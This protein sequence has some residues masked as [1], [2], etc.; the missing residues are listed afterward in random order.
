MTKDRHQY[1]ILAA[2][3]VAAEAEAAP[4][5]QVLL[6]AVNMMAMEHSEK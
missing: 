1:R 6:Q 4:M 3:A 2:A 5:D